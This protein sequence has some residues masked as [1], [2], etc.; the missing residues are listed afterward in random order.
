MLSS[1]S[2]IQAQKAISTSPRHQQNTPRA[3][4]SDPAAEDPGFQ[5]YTKAAPST[6]AP[7]NM[8]I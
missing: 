5:S 3:L 2:T 8:K 1:R 6:V 4:F 7:R